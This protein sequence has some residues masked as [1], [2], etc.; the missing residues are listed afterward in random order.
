[1]NRFLPFALAIPLAFSQLAE[2]VSAKVLESPTESTPYILG[3]GDSVK[4]DFEGIPSLSGT[5]TVGPDGSVYLPRLNSYIVEGLTINQLAETLKAEYSFYVKNPTLI[6]SQSAYRSVRVLVRG[7]VTRPG[8]YSLTEGFQPQVEIGPTVE[9]PNIASEFQ[10]TNTI[11]S[12]NT[13]RPNTSDQSGFTSSFTWPRLFDALKKSGG[14]T[15]YSDLSRIEII[16]KLPSSYQG[17]SLKTSINFLDFLEGNQDDLNIKLFD[18][19]I[20]RVPA[21]DQ[22]SSESLSIASET[23]MS[24]KSI[25]V[26]IFG[27]VNRPGSII[28]PQGST[29]NQAIAASGGLKLLRGS[30]EFLRLKRNGTSDFRRFS[31]NSKAPTDSKSNPTLVEGDIIKVNNS[32]ISA[33]S[34]ALGEITAP[35]LGIYSIYSIVTP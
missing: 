26:F 22:A 31:Y 12:N 3:P 18:G 6:V 35:A 34:E 2:T 32:L 20:I 28:I 24:P 10:A 16:R 27:R 23:N 8:Y 29:L 5:F 14:A 1:M 4:L 13:R 21:L 7:E 17:K 9:I 15:P 19:D 25:E 11:S 33:A 30:V